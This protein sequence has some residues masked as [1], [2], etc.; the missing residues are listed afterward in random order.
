MYVCTK[1]LL[2]TFC[3]FIGPIHVDWHMIPFISVGKTW[4]WRL[5]KSDG[6]KLLRKSNSELKVS[7]CHVLTFFIK[8]SGSN[9]LMLPPVC[10]SS[11][12]FPAPW[13]PVGWACV[14]SSILAHEVS[15][16]SIS[17][18]N[19]LTE[20][21]LLVSLCSVRALWKRMNYVKLP[22]IFMFA[23]SQIL[24]WHSEWFVC[25]WNLY[26]PF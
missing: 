4:H 9:L 19:V 17:T 16:F 12:F 18:H 11:L 5:I 25:S 2:L 21:L 20:V 14:W 10:Y 6:R 7:M 15:E 26:Y 22:P 1:T 13:A 23:T 8:G 24:T 3:C